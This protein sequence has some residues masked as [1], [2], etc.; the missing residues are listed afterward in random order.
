M[1]PQITVPTLILDLKQCRQ[2]IQ[3]MV[4]KSTENQVVIRPHFKTHQSHEVGR[5]FREQGVEQITVSSLRMAE[6][7][8]E[9]GWKDITVAFPVNILEIERINKLAR[10]VQLNLIVE[11]PDTVDFLA[12][13]A[14]APINIFVE[15]NAGNNRSGKNW[16]DL[17]F[18]ER[19]VEA[20][21]KST[22]L[23]FKGFLGHAGQS[24]FARGAEEILKSH[25]SSI[26]LMNKIR[27]HFS[28][29]YPNLIISLGDTPT[30]S[31]AKDFNGI[32]EIRPGNFVFYD[33]TQ[34][35]IGSCTEA[36]IAVALACPVVALAP[37][38]NEIIVYGGG[39]H[40]S[41]DR[42]VRADG[43]TIFGLLGQWTDDGWEVIT[44]QETYI[45]GLSQEHGVIKTSPER[46]AQ[47]K[48]GDIVP[49]LPVHSCMCADLMK[50][51]ETVDG[52]GMGM[53]QYV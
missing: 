41:K 13:Q 20:L 15:I 22:L 50:S 30:C 49:I 19:I 46:V 29:S 10:L 27:A 37:E 8:A 14:Q 16:N 42:V 52:Q 17:P 3:K 28:S 35:I 32:D 38:R 39:V 12:A 2:N 23:T 53:L 4:Q 7:F 1:I 45:R 48:I 6:Y 51:I 25:H 34:T 40:L 31:V 47:T 26:E 44:E 21:A 24:Y 36:E 11:H 9:D 18:I 5:L 43:K 33:V